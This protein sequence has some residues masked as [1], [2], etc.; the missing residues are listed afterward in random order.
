MRWR[1]GRQS[2]NVEDRRGQ[3]LSGGAKIG[4]GAGLVLVVVVLLL[5][6]DPGQVLQLLGGSGEPVATAPESTSPPSDETGRFL[7]AV[8][9]MTEDVWTEVFAERGAQYVAPTLVLFTDQVQSAC[10]FASAA[11]GPFYCPSDQKLYLDTSFF[12][13][14]S[15]MGGPG[16]FAQAYVI[17]HEVGHHVQ[18]LAG[19]LDQSRQAQ[20]R[21]RDEAIANQIQVQVELQAD[22]YAGVWA[23]HANRTARVLEPGDVQ[24]A[25]A[26]AASIGDDRLQRDAGRRISPEQFTHGTSAQRQ[27]WLMRGLDS[28]DIDRCDTFGS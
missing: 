26:A 10:G 2:G 18:N 17:G 11:S 9:A 7:S 27:E 5:G 8:L 3:R 19:T 12:D 13:E 4:G 1:Q 6:G 22:C 16:D 14:L 23:H 20:S 21:A 15:R 24:E 25:L 28:G